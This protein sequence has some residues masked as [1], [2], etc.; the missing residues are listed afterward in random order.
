MI[1][2][3]NVWI[4]VEA[5][6]GRMMPEQLVNAGYPTPLFIIEVSDAFNFTGLLNTQDKQTTLFVR[7]RKGGDA[8]FDLLDKAIYLGTA[9]VISCFCSTNFL[10]IEVLSLKLGISVSSEKIPMLIRM[11]KNITRI[12]H[13]SNPSSTRRRSR[14]LLGITLSREFHTQS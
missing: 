7:I 9:R 2:A 1:I 14:A 8:F 10:T 4:C 6:L 5:A 3:I 13:I 12:T 11:I